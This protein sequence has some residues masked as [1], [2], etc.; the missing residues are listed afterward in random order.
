[1]PGLARVSSL[2]ASHSQWRGVAVG[3]STVTRLR[4]QLPDMQGF[5]RLPTSET[6]LT[7]TCLLLLL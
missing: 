6:L 7:V 2:R 4:E 5:R 1:M 3:A